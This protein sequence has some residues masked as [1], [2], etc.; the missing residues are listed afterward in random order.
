MKAKVVAALLL[1]M[2][3]ALPALATGASFIPDDCG[4]Q[5]CS[6]FIQLGDSGECVRQIVRLLAERGYLSAASRTAQFT[7]KV[8]GAVIQF[9]QDNDLP[10]TGT[11]DD[12][13]L[14]L[15][16]WGMLPEALDVEM[17]VEKGRP[18]T[19]PEMVYIPT[20]G[21]SKRHS[22]PECSGMYDPRKVSI[23]NAAALGF[24]PC[25]KCEAGREDSLH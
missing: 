11:L 8:E 6:C 14:T 12:D 5:P 17:P 1:A 9:Q 10:A 20:D 18:E 23:R 16:I 21:G 2:L 15:L 7:R 24:E 13:T 25:K 3:L 19:Y 4:L 22:R